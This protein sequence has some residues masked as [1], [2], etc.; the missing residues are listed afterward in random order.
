VFDVTDQVN[1]NISKHYSFQ[2]KY[3]IHTIIYGGSIN[4]PIG[5]ESII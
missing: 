1:N 4:K 5:I 2:G 3:S